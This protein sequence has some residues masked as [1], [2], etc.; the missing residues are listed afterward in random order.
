MNDP[1]QGLTAPIKWHQDKIARKIP[2]VF[3]GRS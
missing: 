2:L 1:I 3:H